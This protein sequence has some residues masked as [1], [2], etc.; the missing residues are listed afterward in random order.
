MALRTLL[1]QW[2]TLRDQC[3][4]LLWVRLK[5][6]SCSVFILLVGELEEVGHT[7]SSFVRVFRQW[8]NLL[9][10]IIETPSSGLFH[11]VK[12]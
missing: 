8:Y 7:M 3:T 6:T 1:I 12:V 4:W 2:L 9:G 11:V 5:P 10:V